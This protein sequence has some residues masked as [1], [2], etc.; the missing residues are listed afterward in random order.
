MN[1]CV[2]FW[3]EFQAGSAI[4][5]LKARLASAR[6]R[7][8]W[9]ARGRASTAR[10]VVPDN[11]V[12]LRFGDIIPA[13]A[14]LLRRQSPRGGPVGAHRRVAARVARKTGDEAYW[15]SIVKRGEIEARRDGYRRSAATWDAPRG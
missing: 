6:P 13:D 2:G 3:E 12:R 4:A 1:A 9:R 7:E 11:L 15:G 10:Q 8:A 14:R 5:A